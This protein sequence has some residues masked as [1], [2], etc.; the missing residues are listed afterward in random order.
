MARQHRSGRRCCSS[1]VGRSNLALAAI[2]ISVFALDQL[3]KAAVASGLAFGDSRSVI[4]GFF[5]LVHVRNTGMAFSL[6]HDADAWFRDYALPGVQFAVIA[7]LVLMLRRMEVGGLGRVALALIL[8]GA[9]GN[10][11]DRLLHGYVTDFLDFYVGALHWPAF[12]VAD[13][14]ITV[15]AGLLILESVLGR[16]PEGEA[17]SEA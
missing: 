11:V 2:G 3:S 10:L 9:A 1:L 13:S 16:R 14:A 7:A 4:D 5:R 12:N 8:G 17:G 6:F 15:G